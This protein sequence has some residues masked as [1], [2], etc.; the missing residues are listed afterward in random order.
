VLLRGGPFDRIP[1]SKRIAPPLP[2]WKEWLQRWAPWLLPP[3]KEWTVAVV[4]TTTGR[5]L[6][7][8]R[9]SDWQE[10]R[11]SED[12]TTLVGTRRG[13]PRTSPVPTPAPP[14]IRVW[15][16][17]P[18]RAWLWAIVSGMMAA[19]GLVLLRLSWRWLRG[20]RRVSPHRSR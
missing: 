2:A 1:P 4:E 6:F 12:G 7:R 14:I 13:D 9:Q 20:K 8:M 19:A 15:D 11:L 3:A 17:Y 18:G 10:Y 16:V 5:E